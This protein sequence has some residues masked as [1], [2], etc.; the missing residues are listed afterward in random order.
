MMRLLSPRST[1]AAACSSFLAALAW[2][3]LALAQGGA[4]PQPAPPPAAPSAAPPVPQQPEPWFAEKPAEAHRPPP[5]PDTPPAEGAYV[6]LPPAPA[7]P[8]DVPP[9]PDED[10]SYGS[11][12]AAL[13]MG[14]IAVRPFATY[15][16]DGPRPGDPSGVV[17]GHVGIRGHATGIT[18]DMIVR[19]DLEAFLG[20]SSEGVE[21]EGRGFLSL[22]LTKQ[23]GGRNYVM[24]RFGAGGALLGNPV[25]DYQVADLPAL[26]LGFVHAGADGFIEIAPRV[27]MGVLQMEAFDGGSLAPDPA[28]AV[29]GRI[30][31]GGD[32]L[33]STLDYE[34][35][36]G[37]HAVQIGALTACFAEKFSIC[38]DGRLASASLP[39]GGSDRQ[40]VT[41]ISGGL[42][43]GLG[44]ATVEH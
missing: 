4:A 25:V 38:L 34:V 40:R 42:S 39:A 2:G 35:I 29:G 22:G 26:E 12:D 43:V 32:T 3:S 1:R 37:D 11:G 9:P 5:P 7:L 44:V 21:G 10:G 27:A 28:P 16:G 41:A 30:L 20:A 36:T 23:I 15:V 31:A 14:M 33:W 18:D 17:A 24:F 13:L 6:Q 8:P 19:T